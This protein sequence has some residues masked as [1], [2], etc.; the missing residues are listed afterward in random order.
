LD[1]GRSERGK[2]HIESAPNAKE[3]LAA[4]VDRKTHPIIEVEHGIALS[5]ERRAKA[6][7][8]RAAV[9][10]T[11]TVDS[12]VG[13]VS[14]QTRAYGIEAV[15]QVGNGCKLQGTFRGQRVSKPRY[16]KGYERPDV[17]IPARAKIAVE[18]EF[19]NV[20]LR[21]RRQQCRETP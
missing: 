17:W 9:D 13:I 1:L 19:K 12:D 6:E 21:K 7:T 11:H 4:A 2:T 5:R 3:G 20:G 14:R 8:G 10:N 18:N 16:L 15:W